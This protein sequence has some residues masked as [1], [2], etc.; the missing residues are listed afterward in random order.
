MEHCNYM[1]MRNAFW[2]GRRDLSHHLKTEHYVLYKVDCFKEKKT[3]PFFKGKP[4][5]WCIWFFFLKLS[6]PSDLPRNA[7]RI[8]TI[9]VEFL[10]IEHIDYALET[11]LAGKY[12]YLY[13]TSS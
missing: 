4:E 10:C 12:I 11:G 2:V 5:E 9:L 8:F 3:L 13:Y 7:F 1:Y 6:D